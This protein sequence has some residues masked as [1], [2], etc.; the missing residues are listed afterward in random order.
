MRPLP[1]MST[2]LAAIVVLASCGGDKAS[3][4]HASTAA[5][6]PPALA[7]DG[8]SPKRNEF[9][10]GLSPTRLFGAVTACTLPYP[11]SFPSVTTF[12]V[13]FTSMRSG[14]SV[15]VALWGQTAGMRVHRAFIG[16]YI[17]AG[18]VG[19]NV[20]LTFGGQSGVVIA[21]GAVAVSDPIE[22]AVTTG[23]RYAVSF[24][25]DGTVPAGQDIGHDGVKAPCDCPET[26]SMPPGA[27]A[28]VTMHGLKWVTVLGAPQRD[29]AVLGDSIAAGMA[30]AGTD[31]RF[32]ALAQKNLGFPV[33]DAS[34]GGDGV[35]RAY[36]RLDTDVLAL[37][38]LT[39]CLV[40]VGTNDVHREDPQ[41]VIDGLSKIYRA[42]RRAGIR[43]W[44]GT[45]LPKGSGTLTAAAEDARQVINGFIRSTTMVEGY[46]DFATAV[47][48][49]GNPS[50]PAAGMLSNDG[51]HP[52][53]AGH[54]V[55]ADAMVQ[56][57][58]G[59]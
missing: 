13:P 59:P 48:S 44:G 18:I 37:P 26:L 23:S 50:Q 35:E 56:V 3:A 29:V 33:I 16:P 20:P 11:E 5:P 28:D 24:S 53:N 47:A 54:K 45:I 49:P 42:L 4:P 10:A 41:Y 31:M 25:A 57:F 39:D 40:T 51:I 30:A 19:A 12:R 38:N 17:G 7:A 22:L 14:S 32:I 55:M 15:Q 1:L 6:L 58:R 8:G 9:D 21:P 27:T 36:F 52:T 43:P 34:E 2:A 46:V